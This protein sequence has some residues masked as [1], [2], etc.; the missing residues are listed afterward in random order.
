MEMRLINRDSFWARAEVCKSNLLSIWRESVFVSGKNI[1]LLDGYFC[2]QELLKKV[3]VWCESEINVQYF[4]PSFLFVSVRKNRG[5]K[6]RG[7]EQQRRD[8]GLRENEFWRTER[9]QKRETERWMRNC[10]WLR[11][12]GWDSASFLSIGPSSGYILYRCLKL[13]FG[14]D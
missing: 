14:L 7:D 5:R 10:R 9:M 2:L 8:G 13:P 3:I 1:V 11:S 6:K 4:V 12:R